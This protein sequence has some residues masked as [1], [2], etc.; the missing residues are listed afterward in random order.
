MNHHSACDYE[1]DPA[2]SYIY[3]SLPFRQTKE[4]WSSH[5]LGGVLFLA[6]SVLTSCCEEIIR[7]IKTPSG[8]SYI[9]RRYQCNTGCV[10]K[11]SAIT[12][13]S[14]QTIPPQSGK[15]GVMAKRIKQTLTAWKEVG[16]LLD[17]SW[18]CYNKKQFLD[19]M[20]Q[21]LSLLVINGTRNNKRT[22]KLHFL[23]KFVIQ[24]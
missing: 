6:I 11:S 22:L 20:G 1:A 21:K 9:E 10:K 8:R 13:L 3:H 23:F 4:L 14:I 12:I 17:L 18:K 5:S 15:P 24:F 19:H 2:D 16:V 7:K